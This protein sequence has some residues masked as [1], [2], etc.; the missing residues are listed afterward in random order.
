MSTPA[1]NV[2][3]TSGSYGFAPSFGETLLYAMNLCGVR[4]TALTQQHY[5]TGRMAANMVLSESSA[6]GVN[7][8]QVQL[9]CVAL[10]QGCA[11]YILP[12]NLI[13]LLDCYVTQNTGAAEI[14]RLILPISRT[15]YASFQN[16]DQQGFS[17]CYWL[18]RLLQPT[19][20]LW[21]VPDGNQVAFKYYYLRQTQDTA[22]ANG[23]VP[24]IPVYF[25]KWFT[26]A[27]ASQLALIWNPGQAPMLEALADKAYA[28]AA[29]QNVESSNFYITP[30]LGGY[31]R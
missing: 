14:D 29:T 4:T 17:T 23:A 15:E 2:T 26:L 22:L 10:T 1:G 30:Q 18:N 3:N 6:R 28:F 13:V 16:K 8:W 7:L 11:T 20:S 25:W 27:L 21:P 5:E 19:V 31:Y 9:G 12:T 24:E